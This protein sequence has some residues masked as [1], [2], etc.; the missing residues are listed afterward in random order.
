MARH[1]LTESALVR[2]LLN[3]RVTDRTFPGPDI[4]TFHAGIV[5]AVAPADRRH[6]HVLPH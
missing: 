4:V 3:P 2:L 1:P 5:A 6:V